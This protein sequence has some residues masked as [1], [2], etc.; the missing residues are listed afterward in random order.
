M[1]RVA[2]DLQA[3]ELAMD[4]W[5]DFDALFQKYGGVQAGCWCM[6][7]QR[8]GPTPG[9][10]FEERMHNNRSEK[11]R[12]AATGEAHGILVYSSGK[13]VGWCQYGPSSE[14]PRID[15]SRNYRN[16]HPSPRGKLSGE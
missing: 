2:E 16:L 6:Y 4:T 12:L 14:L 13:A 10:T 9:K 3:R 5:K 7:Y 15:A 11:K 8:T 1:E